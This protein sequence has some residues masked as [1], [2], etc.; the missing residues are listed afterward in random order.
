MRAWGVRLTVGGNW[1]VR[2]KQS[3]H[4]SATERSDTMN[5]MIQHLVAAALLVLPAVA[6]ADGLP[7]KNGRYPGPVLVFTL[8]SE[9]KQVIDHFRTCHLEHFMTMNVYT[10]YV[11]KLT[12][13]QAS[14][15]RAKTGF[16][17]STFE[18]YETYLGFN[19]AGPHWNLVLRFSENQI[20]IPLDLIVSDKEAREN[21]EM[22][23]WKQPNPCFS[24]RS[25]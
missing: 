4:C 5:R 6:V 20:E 1:D 13:R 24:A 21:H 2:L 22:Q 19:N 16:S 7:L 18:V 11:F 12:R 25:N 8:T 14:V 15:L 9:Q 23:G 17:P 3:T 10:P